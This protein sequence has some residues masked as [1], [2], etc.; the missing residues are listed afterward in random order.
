MCGPWYSNIDS[1]VLRLYNQGWYDIIQFNL[2]WQCMAA[3]LD[4]SSN[5]THLHSS[6][7]QQNMNNILTKLCFWNYKHRQTSTSNAR[8]TMPKWVYSIYFPKQMRQGGEISSGKPDAVLVDNPPET[9]GATDQAANWWKYRVWDFWRLSNSY[10]RL[11]EAYQ[12]AL[13]QK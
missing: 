6:F 10:A 7:N 12:H 1:L 2:V 13:R 8:Q 4:L 5:V 3:F 11:P 9:W